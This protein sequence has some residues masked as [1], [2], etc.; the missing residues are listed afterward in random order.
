MIDPDWAQ[1]T[2]ACA[3]VEV[4][5]P[6]RLTAAVVAFGPLPLEQRFGAAIPDLLLPIRP[7]RVAATVPDDSSCVETERLTGVLQ[8]PTDVYVVA[9]CQKLRIEA[10]DALEKF[11]D[12]RPVDPEGLYYF[13]RVLKA[14]GKSDRAREMFEQAIDS[15]N[16][17]PS[18]RE[19]EIRKWKRLAEKEI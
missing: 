15:V 17:S 2:P 13:G 12:R 14:Q 6:G 18:Y 10:A 9:R 8:P 3:V 5:G 7:D 11:V 16:S 19:R 4:P 1:E